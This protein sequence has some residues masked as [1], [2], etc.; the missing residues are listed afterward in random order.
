M[1]ITDVQPVGKRISVA[2]GFA[3]NRALPGS[4]YI[5]DGAALMLSANVERYRKAME[6][7]PYVDERGLTGYTVD[8]EKI[9][10]IWDSAL[11]RVNGGEPVEFAEYVEAPKAG[12]PCVRLTRTDTGPHDD[13]DIIVDRHRLA[14]VLH[15]TGADKALSPRERGPLVFYRGGEPVALLMPM[16]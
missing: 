9:L 3:G 10:P 16:G 15:V 1:S 14:L 6:G 5:T 11:D 13:G 7:K 12:P 8:D 4:P 2:K